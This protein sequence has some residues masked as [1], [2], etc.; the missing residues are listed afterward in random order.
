L[1]KPC[2]EPNGR[3][4]IRLFAVKHSSSSAALVLA[5]LTILS[6]RPRYSKSGIWTP[7]DN[8][9][10]NENL[11]ADIL[12]LSLNI[13]NDKNPVTTL[14]NYDDYLLFTDPNGSKYV[15]LRERIVLEDFNN[16]FLD[17]QYITIPSIELVKFDESQVNTFQQAS[18]DLTI[19]K[20]F[21]SSCTTFDGDKGYMENILVGNPWSN[22]TCQ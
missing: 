13:T 3:D 9:N 15:F 20:V 2:I 7:C 4:V 10:D 6:E 21:E 11:N 5:G 8:R 19:C 12:T 17:E 1:T 22:N 14:G 16:L 18:G